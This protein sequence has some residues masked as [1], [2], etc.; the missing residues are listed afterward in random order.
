[1]KKMFSQYPDVV[2]INELMDMLK[3][4]KNTAYTLLREEKIKNVKICKRY[5]IPKRYIIDYLNC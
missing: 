5:R 4:S 2:S 1:M 3:I